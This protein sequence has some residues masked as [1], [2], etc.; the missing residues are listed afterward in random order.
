MLMFFVPK[1]KSPFFY[2][3]EIQKHKDKHKDKDHKHKDHKKEKGDKIKHSNRYARLYLYCLIKCKYILLCLFLN[4]I[5]WFCLCNKRTMEKACVMSNLKILTP[6]TDFMFVCLI[7]K[8]TAV[9]KYNSWGFFSPIVITDCSPWVYTSNSDQVLWIILVFQ[10]TSRTWS[11]TFLALCTS[12]HKEHS[13]KKHKDKEK[14]KHSNG[15][16]DKHK[17]KHKEKDKDKKR[18]EKVCS[19]SITKRLQIV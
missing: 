4:F 11:L 15:G 5:S 16:S 6:A 8:K 14:L 7:I 10:L 3:A 18:E 17:E 9:R 1:H 12:E 13:E 19:S 2:F